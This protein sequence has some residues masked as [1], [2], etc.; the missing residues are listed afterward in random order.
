MAR[1]NEK[2]EVQKFRELIEKE[3]QLLNHPVN[4][5]EVCGTHT[6]AISRFG[7][8][9]MLPEKIKLISGP[10]CPVC[11]TPIEE[12]DRAIEL[13][14]IDNVIITTFGDMM[15]VPGTKTNLNSQKAK[16]KDIR[17]VYSAIDALEIA[18][19]NPGKDVIFLGIGFETTSPS[20]GIA[21]KQAKKEKLGNFYVLPEFKV[22]IPPMEALLSDRE[23][24]LHGFIAPGHASTI[25]GGKTYEYITG[26][27]KIPCVITGFEVLDVLQA[28]L[29]I[30]KQVNKSEG[31]VEIQYT[32]AV[33]YEGNLI[34]QD[35]MKEVFVTVDS[36]WRGI[37]VIPGSGLTLNGDYKEFNALNKYKVDV[38]YSKEPEECRCGDVLKGKCTPADCPLFDSGCSP[39]NPA[40]ACMVSSEGSCSAFYRY[41]R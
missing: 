40:G 35:I 9:S 34:A 11:V 28:V 41:E 15:R 18:G 36:N 14:E 37:G 19:K 1:M 27:Y 26:K 7:I 22:I 33:R 6:M 12:V 2:E 24:N 16:G 5:M 13:S 17:I 29:M 25:V 23:L 39:E 8:R 38:A 4:L 30:I 10:G 32:R 3:A 21:V 20:V 31:K